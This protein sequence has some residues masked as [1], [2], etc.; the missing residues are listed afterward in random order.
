MATTFIKLR[1][2]SSV[3]FCVFSWLPWIYNQ[4]LNQQTVNFDVLPSISLPG[5]CKT[6]FPILEFFLL[7]SHDTNSSLRYYAWP[8]TRRHLAKASF[9][10]FHKFPIPLADV[11]K[12][13]FQKISHFHLS[14]LGLRHNLLTRSIFNKDWRESSKSLNK[15]FWHTFELKNI[16]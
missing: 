5:I 9:W 12:I 2:L 4:N 15:G 13:G 14:F 3:D 6:Q 16:H 11:A 8:L 1:I 10:Q 7:M